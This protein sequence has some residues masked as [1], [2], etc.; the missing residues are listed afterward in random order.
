[1]LLKYFCFIILHF[2]K[3]LNIFLEFVQNIFRR[4][5]GGAEFIA[6]K[7]K[8]NNSKNNKGNKNNSNNNSEKTE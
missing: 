6:E 4:G 2:C 8:K 5:N 1:M 7:N 3:I